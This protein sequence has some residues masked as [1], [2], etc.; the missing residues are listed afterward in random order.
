MQERNIPP[1]T[2]LCFE[3]Q[4]S[5]KDMLQY[6]RVIAR[7]LHISAIASGLEIAGPIQWI[8]VGAD[9]QPD[10]LFSLTIALPIVP[11]G[12]IIDIPEFAVKNLPA[13]RCISS[14]H[15]GDWGRLGETYGLIIGN[16]ISESRVMT[17]ENRELY[18]HMDFE[19]PDYNI[20]EVQVGIV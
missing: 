18:I 19:N 20:T 14:R 16:V 10:T 4:T 2:A 8:Y 5:F 1:L 11:P 13:F 12:K 6:V 17:G 15:D 7:R 9:G 3:T